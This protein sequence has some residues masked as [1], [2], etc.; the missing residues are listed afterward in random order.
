M[1]ARWWHTDPASLLDHL[2]VACTLCACRQQHDAPDGHHT[3]LLEVM[4]GQKIERRSQK[5]EVVESG[6]R[7]DNLERTIF[8]DDGDLNDGARS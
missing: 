3:D 4:Q 6:D 8:G 1:I 2:S 7:R 5:R